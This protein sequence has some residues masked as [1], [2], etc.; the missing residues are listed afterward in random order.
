MLS[1]VRPHAPEFKQGNPAPGNCNSPG[2]QPAMPIIEACDLVKK[3]AMGGNAVQALRGISLSV[4]PGE[5]IAITGPS[6]SG[7]STLM[8]LL[9]LLDAPTLGIYRLDGIDTSRLGHAAV[10]CLRNTKVGFVFQNFN[11]LPRLNAQENVELPLVY[12]GV[13]RKQRRERVRELLYL[14]GLDDRGHHRPCQLSGGQQQRVAIARALANRPALI[15]ADE[16]TG[17]LD[18]RSSTGIMKMLQS[19]SRQ[20]VTVALVT[21]DPQI[22]CYADRTVALRDGRIVADDQRAEY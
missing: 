17:A 2:S 9:G 18:S 7:K 12:A 6:G 4:D 14:V 13:P 15:L 16:P 10:A 1:P 3:Y 19:L 20:K 21:H 8:S 5:F 11:L 22:A